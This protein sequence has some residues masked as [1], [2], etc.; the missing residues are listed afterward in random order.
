MITQGPD[1]NVKLAKAQLGTVDCIAQSLSVGPITSA[2]LLGGILAA[3]GGSSG[4]LYMII[5]T[6]G[7]LAFGRILVMYAHR[8]AGAGAIFEDVTKALGPTSG[9]ATSG[10][11]YLAYIILGGPTMLIGAGFLLSTF[12]TE[13]M[14]VDI[15]WW[16]ISLVILVA[17]IIINIVGVTISVRTQL[18]IFVCSVI[19]Y[20]ITAVVI[21]AKGGANGNTLEVFNPSSPTS[22][23]FLRAFMFAALL[24]VGVESS[25][26]LGEETRE[27]RRSIPRAIIWTIL[28]VGAFVVLTQ[29]AGTIG[30]GLPHVAEAWASDPLGLATLGGQYVGSWIVPLMELGLILDIIAVAIGFMVASSRGVFALSRGGLLPRSWDKTSRFETPIGGIAVFAVASVIGIVANIFAPWRDVEGPYMGFF[31]GATMGGLLVLIA[32]GVLVIGAIRILIQGHWKPIGWLYAG[33]AA[34]T[35]GAALYGQFT[36][37]PSD[38]TGWGVYGALVL[39]VLC[40]VWGVYHGV[41]K[42]ENPPVV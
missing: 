7:V 30:F 2:A 16:T 15:P 11:Y 26:S 3:L 41:I 31:V 33:A 6:I 25:V 14:G 9:I 10:F 18:I 1:Q 38:Y 5:A 42:K 17:V 23:N 27:P 19:P 28:I 22:G 24:F 35:I 29:Y 39:V 13:H 12:F 37:I 21:I 4:P 34:F 40:I 20:L 8:Y 36:P 32:Y